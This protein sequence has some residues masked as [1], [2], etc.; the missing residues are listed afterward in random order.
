[1]HRDE[2]QLELFDARGVERLR[3]ASDNSVEAHAYTARIIAFPQHRNVG[4]IRHV[5]ALAASKSGRARDS[6]WVQ[7]RR[8]LE[9]TLTAAGLPPAE[10]RLQVMEFR[11]AVSAELQRLDHTDR[12]SPGG[13]A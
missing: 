7:A 8:A 6:Y 10:V 5:A 2:D 3:P 9:A 4:R 13:A 12:R 11:D 1:M